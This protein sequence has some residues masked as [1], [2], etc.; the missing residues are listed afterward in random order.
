[1]NNLENI[2]STD[3]KGKKTLKVVLLLTSVYFV[4]Q[5]VIGIRI[6]SLAVISDAGHMFIDVAGLVMALLA[7]S[8]AQKPPTPKAMDLSGRLASLLKHLSYIV[9]FF[10]EAFQELFPSK[11]RPSM[12]ILLQLVCII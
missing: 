6:D 11:N 7:I 10:I 3:D 2:L 9:C 5:I 1:M 8:F 4:I 12:I